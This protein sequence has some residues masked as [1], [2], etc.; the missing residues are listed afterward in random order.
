VVEFPSEPDWVPEVFVV[1]VEAPD[2]AATVSAVPD[3][4]SLPPLLTRTIATIAAAA[5]RSVI[6]APRLPTSEP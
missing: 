6:T 3:L 2:P 4:S 1:C 5:A